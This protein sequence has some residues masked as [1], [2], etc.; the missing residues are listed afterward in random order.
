MYNEVIL[1]YN[2]A[3]DSR[4]Q[5]TQ[6]PQCGSK[7]LVLIV[8]YIFAAIY[9]SSW[10]CSLDLI[11]LHVLLILCLLKRMEETGLNIP[12]IHLAR[13]VLVY[14]H[15]PEHRFR[16]KSEWKWWWRNRWSISLPE[17]GRQLHE[18][19]FKLAFLKGLTN[20]HEKGEKTNTENNKK[21]I[22]N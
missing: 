15:R 19:Q 4:L 5:T 12:W 10:F 16:R 3:I 13:E 8:L 18:W 7:E 11:L 2:Y 9:W 21:K 1:R 22:S 6:K 17:K 20:M 14:R